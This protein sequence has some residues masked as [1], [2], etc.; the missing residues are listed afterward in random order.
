MSFV[1]P[2]ACLLPPAERPGR[3]AAFD[4]LLVR[5]IRGVRRVEPG[6]LRLALR[7]TEDVE[8][9]VRELVRLEGACCS[10]L[11]IAIT[12]GAAHL[13]VDIRVPPEHIPV[14]DGLERFARAVTAE[15]AG[16]AG[17]AR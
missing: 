1:I 5:A 2:E 16:T 17:T 7:A 15:T 8:K 4:G 13:T 10:F 12:A 11:D 6:H 9:G 14:L 3:A